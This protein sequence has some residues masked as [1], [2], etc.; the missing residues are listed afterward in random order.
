[1]SELI[2]LATKLHVFTVAMLVT[3]IIFIIL[4]LQ[5]ESD[6]VKLTKKYER[7]SLF[8]YFFLSSILFTGLILFTVLKFKWS[9]RVILMIM[10]ILHLTVTSIKLHKIFKNT[11]KN[12]ID[13][14][15]L[16]R[17]YLK[18]KY[19]ID[20]VVLVIVGVVSFAIHI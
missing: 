2:L 3:L 14:Q 12:D 15:L 17:K 10:A 19:L 8:Y 6:Y 5:S 9:I 7:Y 11:R 16:F 13:S 4:R 1:M 18:K 20:I